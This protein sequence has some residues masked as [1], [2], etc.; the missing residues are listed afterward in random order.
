MSG[1]SSQWLPDGYGSRPATTADVDAV[2][3]L[4]TACEY[5]LRGRAAT[6]ADVIAA[7]LNTPGLEVKSDAVLVHHSGSE[8]A[9][10]GWVKGRRA[11]VHVHPGHTRRGLGSALLAWTEARAR[12][13]GSDR[14]AHTVPDSWP[15]R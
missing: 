11:T 12:R 1:P 2:H 3:Q 5:E 9:G 14:L 7:G 6:G 13:L 8:L 10:W 4:V 15:G